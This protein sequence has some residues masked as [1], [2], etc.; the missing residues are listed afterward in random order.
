MTVI[1]SATD[2]NFPPAH[3]ADE[4]GIVA[5]GG[6]FSSERLIK[7][8]KKGIFPWPHRNL[9]ILWF[10]PD[11]RFVLEPKKIVLKQT[12]RKAMRKS[13]L[14]IRA[15]EKFLDVIK[16]CAESERNSQDGT[17]ITPEMIAG[18]HEL[19]RLGLAHSIEAYDNGELVGGLYGL[20]LGAIFFGESMFFIKPDASKICFVTL[21]AH[22]VEWKFSLIDCQAHTDHLTN[23]GALFI[24]RA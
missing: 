6:D 15:D 18:Y 21:A 14:E 4:Q 24:T 20:A 19:Y 16:R 9:P 23:F 5:I 8:Y 1:L 7:A 13:K 3:H 10:C 22:L 12:L 17:W 2:T 11:P